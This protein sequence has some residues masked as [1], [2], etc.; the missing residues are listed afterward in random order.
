[1]VRSLFILLLS[2]V[3]LGYLWHV[4]VGQAKLLM[5]RQPVQEALQD[6]LLSEEERQ[7]IR[8]IIHV[9]A[10]ASD[11][12]G[13]HR[14]DSYSTF[15]EIEGPYVSYNL[16]AAPKDAVEAH[17]WSFPIIGR[18]PYKGFFRKDYAI[19]EQQK[20]ADK[21]YDTYLRGVRAFSTLGHFDDPILSSMLAYDNFGLVETI[22]HELTHQTVW[23]KGHVSF[24]ESLADFVG[25]QGT[26]RYLSSRYGEASPEYVDFENLVS[27]RKVFEDYM[28]DLIGDVEDLYGQDLSRQDKIVRRQVLFEKAKT[29]YPSIFPRMKTSYYRA[30]FDDLSLNNA[31]LLSFQR[32]HHG[33]SFF[34]KTLA[35]FGGDFRTMLGSFKNLRPDQIPGS[36]STP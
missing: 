17:T 33:G 16:T 23:V 10:F 19:R 2:G 20:M 31:V 6:T 24:N 34:E 15:V 9:K 13:L 27:D 1:M 11:N 12:L 21:G 26:Q 7:K 28:Q 4:T 18:V 3:S 36:F 8:L 29:T 5:G 35:S 32:Y 25:E 14:S 30:F 22:I